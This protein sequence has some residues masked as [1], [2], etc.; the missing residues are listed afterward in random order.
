MTAFAVIFTAYAL[1][2]TAAVARAVWLW[3]QP[4][5]ERQQVDDLEAAWLL[6]EDEPVRP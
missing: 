5:R 4:R 6:T 2:V 3:R 1:F